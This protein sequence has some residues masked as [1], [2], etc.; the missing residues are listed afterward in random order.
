[1]LNLLIGCSHRTTSFP[2]TP[3][4]RLDSN[5]SRT[6]TYVVCLDCG[7]KFEYDWQEMRIRKAMSTPPTGTQEQPLRT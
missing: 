2:F 5:A 3:R 4:R 7:R 1:M 6:V